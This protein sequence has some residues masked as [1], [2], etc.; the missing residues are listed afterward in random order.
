MI[1]SDEYDILRFMR[2][3]GPLK[4]EQVYKYFENKINGNV[5][6]IVSNMCARGILAYD[7]KRFL[8]YPSGRKNEKEVDFKMIAAFWVFL[9]FK[10][11]AEGVYP[12]HYPTQILFVKND[13]QYEI[14]FIDVGEELLLSAMLNEKNPGDVKY[15]IIVEDLNQ[16]PNINVQ[17]VAAYCTRRAGKVEFFKPNESEETSNE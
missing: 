5:N 6:R 15:L 2:F 14:A 8:L 9:R 4:I 13:A 7:N 12:T 11:D 1:K 16:I 17:N 10:D 3:F